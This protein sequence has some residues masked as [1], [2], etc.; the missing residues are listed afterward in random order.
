MT[1]EIVFRFVSKIRTQGQCKSINVPK[2][3][4]KKIMSE[5]EHPHTCDVTIKL[6]YPMKQKE[7]EIENKILDAIVNN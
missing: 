5:S 3:L 1:K 6:I 4:H 7:A 2:T